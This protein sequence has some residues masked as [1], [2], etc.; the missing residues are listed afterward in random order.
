LI[1]PID[2]VLLLGKVE[3]LL[4]KCTG[5]LSFTETKTS[6]PGSWPLEI[7]VVGVSEQ[8]ISFIAPLSLPTNSIFK[9]N[10]P[11][12]DEINIDPPT[13]RLISSKLLE[14]PQ[15]HIYVSASFV[16]LTS[17]ELKALRIWVR[18]NNLSNRKSA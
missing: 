13:L 10:S 5:A 7:T 4:E 8:S 16:G 1:K 17:L 18:S 11:L 9:I 14:G 6:V 15:G 12:F 3:A 2:S